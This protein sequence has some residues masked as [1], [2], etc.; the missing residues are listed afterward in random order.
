MPKYNF[1]KEVEVYVVTLNTSGNPVLKYK[2]DISS[3][4]FS[5]SFAQENFRVNTLHAGN[6]FFDLTLLGD[7]YSNG[8]WGFSAETSYKKRYRY[9]GRMSFNF[10]NG[11]GLVH[12]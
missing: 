10:E 1:Q 2:L 3:I 6:D 5:Q 12:P 4:T 8:S 9:N 7:V 11:P